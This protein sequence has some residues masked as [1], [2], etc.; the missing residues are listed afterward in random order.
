MNAT[1]S[2]VGSRP[3]RVGTALGRVALVVG[4]LCAVA[5]LLAGPAY[6][7]EVLPLGASLQTMR[8]AAMV[9]IGGAVAAVVAMLLSVSAPV[10]ARGRGVTALALLVNVMVVAPP[11]FMYWQARQ[12][13]KIHDISTDTANPPTFEAVLPLRKGARNAVAYPPGTAAEQRKGYPDIGPLTLPLAPQVAFERALQAA[14]QMGWDVVAAAP[15]ALRIEATDTTL[16]FGF[17]DDVVV[18]IAPQAQGSVVDVRSLSR[19][20]GS[21]FGTNA[22]RVRAYLGRLADSA[23]RP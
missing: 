13:P 14:Q 6:R 5:A 12:L 8:W 17:K 15:E 3:A 18:R 22:K 23:S 16:L 7:T 19:V 4:V 9:A 20:G 11:L 21:D 2:S 1:V 10:P